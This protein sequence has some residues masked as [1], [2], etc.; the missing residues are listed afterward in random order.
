MPRFI[1]NPSSTIHE[2][3]HSC[4]IIYHITIRFK[5]IITIQDQRNNQTT[6]I[7]R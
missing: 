3:H 7:L 4:M 6:A 5:P 2:S 1:P